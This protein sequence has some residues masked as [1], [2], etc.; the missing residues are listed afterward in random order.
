M[1]FRL[2]DLANI[3]TQ[4][5][6]Y[7][8]ALDVAVTTLLNT[9]SKAKYALALR[10]A[11]QIAI[12]YEN[13]NINIRKDYGTSSNLAGMPLFMPLLLKGQNGIKDLLLESAVVEC[14]RSKTIVST[15]IQGRDTSVDEWINNG[16][17]Q[18]SVD[19]L[20]CNNEPRYPMDLLLRFEQFTSLNSSIEIEHEALNAIGIYEI[21][22][23]SEKP[24][25]RTNHINVQPYAFTCKST[26]PIPLVLQDQSVS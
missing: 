7:N 11:T 5:V 17:W 14:A 12:G 22:I 19:G 13:V 8:P 4:K 26:Q 16:D 9:R 23:L 20:L 6:Q 3:S 18:I 21:V 24:I 10:E 15:V 1:E 25:Q 2:T